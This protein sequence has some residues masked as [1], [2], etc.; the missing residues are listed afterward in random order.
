MAK[1]HQIF[2]ACCL[3]VWLGPPLTV[4]WYIKYFQFYG[5]YHVFT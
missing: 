4:L 2:Y 3:W 5:C 1:L